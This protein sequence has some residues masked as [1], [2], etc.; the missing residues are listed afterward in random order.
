MKEVIIIGF[1]IISSSIMITGGVIAIELA[2]EP[3]DGGYLLVIAG[4]A[5]FIG[6][7]IGLAYVKETK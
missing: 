1:L 2:S 6:S 5:I 4:M 7:V 3:S